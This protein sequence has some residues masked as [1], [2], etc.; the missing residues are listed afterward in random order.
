VTSGDTVYFQ[1]ADFTQGGVSYSVAAKTWY[2]SSSSTNWSKNGATA[3]SPGEVPYIEVRVEFEVDTGNE[4]TK[5]R[6]PKFPTEL[7]IPPRG[8]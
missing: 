3:T 2:S 5:A 4:Q 1:V 8:G 6:K 7:R